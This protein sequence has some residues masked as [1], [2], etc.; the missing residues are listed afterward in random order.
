[1]SE[2]H[3]NQGV[4][5][6]PRVVVNVAVALRPFG[7]FDSSEPIYFDRQDEG[8]DDHRKVVDPTTLVD[9]LV[10]EPACYAVPD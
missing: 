3:P 5:E 8:G 4:E 2:Q 6:T 10:F 9:G 7:R 1:M